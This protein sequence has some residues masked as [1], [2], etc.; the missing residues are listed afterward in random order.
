MPILSIF[1][2]KKR[3]QNENFVLPIQQAK[4]CSTRTWVR[5]SIYYSNKYNN[6]TTA[7]EST[8]NTIIGPATIN[9][10]AAIP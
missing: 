5:N 7:P 1:Y 2:T 9:I 10:F 4:K 3:T 8:P 6:P